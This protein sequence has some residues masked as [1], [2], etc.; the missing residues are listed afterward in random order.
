MK[1]AIDALLYMQPDELRRM[2]AD[3]QAQNEKLR[4]EIG[5]LETFQPNWS[6]APEWAYFWAM[7]YNGNASWYEYEPHPFMT[8]WLDNGG[9]HEFVN[10]LRAIDWRTTLR[11]RPDGVAQHNAAPD[12]AKE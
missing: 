11:V 1:P 5:Q 9:Q 2:I 8:S 6:D 4:Y 7:D 12:A 10:S 3:L